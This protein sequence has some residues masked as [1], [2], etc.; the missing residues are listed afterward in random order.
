MNTL[1]TRLGRAATRLTAVTAAA[2]LAALGFA[3]PAAAQTPV[4]TSTDLDFEGPF[5]A[6][7]GP[8]TTAFSASFGG[9]FTPGEH[10]VS[11]SLSI[12]IADEAFTFS[13]DDFEDFCTANA[14]RTQVDCAL[15]DAPADIGWDIGIAVG[16]ENSAGSYPYTVELAVD[17]EVV[18]TESSEVAIVPPD[19]TGSWQPY[20]FGTF[21][22]TGVAPGSTVGVS[23]EFRQNDPIPESAKAVAL[24]FGGSEFAVGV[25]VSEAYD[26]CIGD[27]WWVT[28]AVTDFPDAPGTVY[29][30]S[31]PISYT[32]DAKVPG[33]FDICNCAYQVFPVDD[34]EY[35]NMFGDLD[36]DAGSDNLLSLQETDGSGTEFGD[37]GPITI[38]TGENP[39][40]LAVEDMNLKGAKG[41]E[42]TIHVE[43]TNDGPADTIG[44]PDGPGNFIILVSL[45]TGVELRGD[46]DFCESP[47]R[48][49]VYDSY[50]PEIDSEL[51]EDADHV[52]YFMGV[53]SGETYTL[54]LDVEITS[55]RTS[56]DGT[57]AVLTRDDNGVDSDLTNNIAKF[58]L[59]A[60]GNGNGNL[61]NTGT[62]LGLIIGIA[63]LVVVAGVV[64]MVLT[65]RKRKAAADG[66]SE[67]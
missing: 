29:T 6:E 67:E 62:S 21:N 64:M 16:D 39:F 59:N 19:D 20:K 7:V 17:G 47:W 28:C 58:S 10:T 44:H 8:T 5:T 27:D 43:F 14:G 63:A 66:A 3:A 49:E 26:N 55:N 48:P 51:I 9:D 18:H 33:P 31:D 2:G 15:E 46:P 25:G 35:Q 61:P 53:K 52:C 57:L 54:D 65:T 13:G 36:W 22:L 42:T 45:P 23:P 38:T 4:P 60:K 56:S 12:D 50:L 41:T 40:D 37:W 32:I 30:I 34:A 11:M 1:D 24:T